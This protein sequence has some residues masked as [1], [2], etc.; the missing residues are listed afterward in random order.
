MLVL[1]QQAIISFHVSLLACSA[2]LVSHSTSVLAEHAGPGK[3]AGSAGQ[4]VVK[5]LGK[6]RVNNLFTHLRKIA[7]HPLLVRNLYTEAQVER[8]VTIA[9]RRCVTRRLIDCSPCA[10]I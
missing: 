5:Q 7:Q 1:L 6:Q 8:L 3:K 4:A 10:T 2:V 9:H